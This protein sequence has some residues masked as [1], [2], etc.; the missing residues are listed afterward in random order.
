MN[1]ANKPRYLLQGCAKRQGLTTMGADMY[2]TGGSC[3]GPLIWRFHR[4][5]SRMD[6]RRRTETDTPRRSRGLKTLA[7]CFYANL[8]YAEQCHFENIDVSF[9][10]MLCG[11][12]W[13]VAAAAG[14]PHAV[15]YRL[16]PRSGRESCNESVATWYK[17][18]WGLIRW[19]RFFTP[20]EL[21]IPDR[22]MHAACS[23]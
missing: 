9:C 17:F 23:R 13:C 15:C 11:R 4:Q 8:Q 18:I 10:E 19:L 2:L 7:P 21:L 12:W 20:Q 22:D 14:P 16:E 3:R 5:Q 6:R 1:L